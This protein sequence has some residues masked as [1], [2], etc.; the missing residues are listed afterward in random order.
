MDWLGYTGGTILTVQLVPQ[1]Y[2]V[3]LYRDATQLSYMFIFMNCVGLSM[4]V[5]YGY[6]G[7]D[8]PLI[9]STGSSLFSSVVLGWSKYML[10]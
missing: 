6:L 3:W 4:M 10:S 2:R 7:N 8:T 9:V 5:T 1:I